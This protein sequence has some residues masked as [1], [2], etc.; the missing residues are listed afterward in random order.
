MSTKLLGSGGFAEVR[1]GTF[2]GNEV[3]VKV[4]KTYMTTEDFVT[5]DQ[6]LRMLV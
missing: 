2:R 6:E 5:E 4:F 1:A 3:A